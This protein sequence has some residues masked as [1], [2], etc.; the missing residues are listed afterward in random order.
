MLYILT[1]SF[2]LC[3]LE[4][5]SRRLKEQASI[6]EKYWSRIRCLRNH[7]FSSFFYHKL[8][9][10]ISKWFIHH[11]YVPYILIRITYQNISYEYLIKGSLSLLSNNICSAEVEIV[12]GY[13]FLHTQSRDTIFVY[14]STNH[15]RLPPLANM[16]A[17]KWQPREYA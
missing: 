10:N 8:R 4:T 14:V 11:R 7:I 3:C 12:I 13:L 1:C 2:F 16:R 17:W 5:F 6:Q 15:S 9:M